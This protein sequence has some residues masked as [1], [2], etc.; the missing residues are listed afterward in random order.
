MEFLI[1]ILMQS[2][3]LTEYPVEAMSRLG[4]ALL[5]TVV[6]LIAMSP[7]WFSVCFLCDIKRVLK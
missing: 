1:N 5:A 4:L 3:G 6:M 7:L 2:I